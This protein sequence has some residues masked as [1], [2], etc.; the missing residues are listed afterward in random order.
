MNTHELAKELNTLARALRLGPEVELEEL[1]SYIS[2]RPKSEPRQAGLL[3]SHK[4]RI[5]LDEILTLAQ[6]TKS[7]MLNFVSQSNIPVILRA[8]D[9]GWDVLGK[10]IRYFSTNRNELQRIRNKYYHGTS[11]ASD[12]L[13]RALSSLLKE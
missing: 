1:G 13:L 9:S 10:I 3:D 12:E 8:R 6:L 7:D 5:N 11:K 2:D 4:K